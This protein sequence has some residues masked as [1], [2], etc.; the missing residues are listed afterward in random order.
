MK[1]SHGYVQ[2]R[3]MYVR[4]QQTLMI[5]TTFR[6][7]LEIMLVYVVKAN[8]SCNQNRHQF[9]CKP[10]HITEF[11]TW[12][13]KSEKVISCAYVQHHGI[14]DTFF[15]NEPRCHP[16]N[17]CDCSTSRLTHHAHLETYMPPLIIKIQAFELSKM[18]VR[19]YG[20]ALFWSTKW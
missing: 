20:T 16:D 7:T 10:S 15:Q 18:Y 3:Q 13:W 19:L 6:T 5:Y 9:Q 4:H 2:H 17:K 11:W 12:K 14:F 1:I 8:I